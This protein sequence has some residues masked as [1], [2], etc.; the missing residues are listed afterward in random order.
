MQVIRELDA[1]N[2]KIMECNDV[3][4]QQGDDAMRRHFQTFHGDFSSQ[5][6]SDP[7]SSE[8]RDFQLRLH[9]RICGKPYSPK[10]ERTHF[11]LD[12]YQDR[13]FPYYLKSLPTASEYLLAIAFML[14]MMNLPPDARVLE[15]GPGWGET[16]ITLAMLG[17]Q[18]TAVDIEPN[19]CEM[20]R[21][22]AVQSRVN[23]EVIEADFFWAEGVTEPYDAVL[24]FE[25]FHH[26][27]DHLR[28]LRALRTAV[29]P[30]GQ[31]IFGAEPIISNHDVPWGISMDGQALWSMR[32]FGWLE[33]NFDEAYFK[34]ALARTGWSAEK[35]K[36]SDVP[37]ATAWRARPVEPES[38]DAQALA[39]SVQW[40]SCINEPKPTVAQLEAS[41]GERIHAEDVV[42]TPSRRELQLELELAAM[43]TSTSWRLTAPIRSLRRMFG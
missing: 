21:R 28:L 33:L 41:A 26:C 29:K 5:A 22:R 25:S 12:T 3:F 24:F 6:P 43:R 38:A 40:Q 2:D 4:T 7:F 15:F 35:Y 37:W 16:T 14:R 8:Y 34:A 27:H 11:D 39:D 30:E 13:P 42:S 1:L 23:I 9:E 20:L 17:V 18:V 19:F 36:S 32:N 10:N 31:I